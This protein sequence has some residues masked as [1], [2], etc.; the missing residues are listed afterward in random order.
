GRGLAA[1]RVALQVE[2][3]AVGNDHFLPV[4]RHL[5]GEDFQGSLT[6]ALLA[7]LA[8]LLDSGGLELAGEDGLPLDGIEQ[9]VQSVRAGEQG[10][11]AL[12]PHRGT[13]SRPRLQQDLCN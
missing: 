9:R 6:H 5:A 11:E 12:T 7:M 2:R 3:R 8:E 13:I 4:S 1:E 10:F